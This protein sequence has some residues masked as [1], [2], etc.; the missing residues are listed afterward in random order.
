LQEI[1]DVT[2]AAKNT[3][4]RHIDSAPGP[5]GANDKETDK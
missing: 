1:V 4:E 3:G 5:N 2:N